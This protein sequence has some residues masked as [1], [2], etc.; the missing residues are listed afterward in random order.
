MKQAI[1][2]YSLSGNTRN[3]AKIIATETGAECMEIQLQKS[4]SSITAYTKGVIDTKAG[5]K[6]RYKN[7]VDI[8]EFDRIWIGTPVWA[9][10]F[11]APLNTMVD[12]CDFSG[13]EVIMFST[14]GGNNGKTFIKLANKLKGAKIIGEKDFL[15]SSVLN[16]KSEVVKWINT[17]K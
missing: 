11:A 13:K 14:N 10:T 3:V 5:L 9:W 17:F 1:I 6:L 15:G 12:E 16:K 8:S 2:F 7:N 4:Y